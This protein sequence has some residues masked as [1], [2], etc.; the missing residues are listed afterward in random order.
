MT[1]SLLH[2]LRLSDG[3]LPIGSYAH[4]AGLE[5][6]VQHG[7]VSDMHTAL[8]FIRK[9]LTNNIRYN[10]A[11]LVSLAWESAGNKNI[12]DIIEL[13]QLANAIKIPS[14]LREASVK[15]GG[16]LLKIFSGQ[17]SIPFFLEYLEACSLRNA[18][19]HFSIV[20]GCIAACL[21]I[22]RSDTLTGYCYSVTNGFV[23]NA[24]KMVPLSQ[25]DGQKIL[26]SLYTEMQEVV[27]LN[28]QPD[29]DLV[30]F[31]NIGFDI[32][33]MQHEKLYSRL[34]MS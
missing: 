10:D 34:Y 3:L 28:I 12:D 2:L 14:E 32:R 22:S 7:H 23:N 15:T 29:K 9:Q 17:I 25:Y 20:F 27:S 1:L 33:S 24:V 30:G 19:S 4:S 18:H 8:D 5:T 13:D 16:R 26:H 6:Y 21:G 31:C 11:A